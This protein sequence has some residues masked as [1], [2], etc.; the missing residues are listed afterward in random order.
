MFVYTHV[1]G[2]TRYIHWYSV[3]ILSHQLGEK[4]SF[5][6]ILLKYSQGQIWKCPSVE[7]CEKKHDL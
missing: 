2:N 6:K 1:P 5:I 3:S 4:I 7:N